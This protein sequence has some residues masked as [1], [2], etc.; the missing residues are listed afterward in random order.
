MCPIYSIRKMVDANHLVDIM[1]RHVPET[2]VS[3]KLMADLVALLPKKEA[4]EGSMDVEGFVASGA[5]LVNCL[6]EVEIYVFTLIATTLMREGLHTDAATATEKIMDRLETLN[7]RSLDVLASKAIS[8]Y[9]L[10]HERIGQVADLRPRLLA[11]YRSACVHQDENTQAV[12]LNL[13][14]R[15]YLHFNLIDQAQKLVQN[16]DFPE[17]VS[18]NQY[19]RYLYYLGRIMAI[20]LMYSDAHTRLAA[21]MRKVPQEKSLGF[22]QSVQKLIIVVQ[23][24]MGDMPEKSVFRDPNFE[25]VLV[26]Y[27]HLTAAV[28]A[29][30]Y[31]QFQKVMSDNAETFK[32]DKCVMLVKRLGHNVL[33][34]GLKKISISY[35]RISFLHIAEKLHLESAETAEYLCA[36]AIKDGVIEATIDHESSCLLSNRQ[37]DIYSS[38]QPQKEL[39]KRISFC[40]DIHNDAVKGMQYRADSHKKPKDKSKPEPDEK[41]LEEL[42][43][44]FEEDE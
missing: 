8:Y 1:Y 30:D 41:T 24:L 14:L 37:L 20:R 4:V 44:E 2:C 9:S 42:I 32:T 35:S 39:H 40:L 11:M 12:I 17:N 26:P 29:G 27:Y 3:Y 7:R 43:R 28:K 31:L 18:N 16:T 25:Q 36:K 15:H 38:E 21:A 13:L 5:M 34:T 33:K 19:C 10:T 22:M 23:L 6:P